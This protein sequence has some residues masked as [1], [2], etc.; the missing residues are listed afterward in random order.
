MYPFV[1]TNVE[2]YHHGTPMTGHLG[3]LESHISGIE[4][5]WS[6]YMILDNSSSLASFGPWD[7]V[8]PNI[9]FFIMYGIRVAHSNSLFAILYYYLK[10]YILFMWHN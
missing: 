6:T 3:V 1:S 5:T 4:N 8:R 7:G 2:L 9:S 10:A